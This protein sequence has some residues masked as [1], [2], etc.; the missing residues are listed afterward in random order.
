MDKVEYVGHVISF[1]GVTF[2]DEKRVKVL[3]FPLPSTQKDLQA[4]LGLVNYF[5]D[6]Y[7][8]PLRYLQRARSYSTLEGLVHLGSSAQTAAHNM[9][10]TLLE[11]LPRW[12]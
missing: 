12:S 2:S 10:T 8:T 6:H 7:P 9:L 11:N 5:R 1:E 3:D 4:F